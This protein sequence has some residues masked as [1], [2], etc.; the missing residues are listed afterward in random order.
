[1]KGIGDSQR[2]LAFDYGLSGVRFAGDVPRLPE[3]GQAPAVDT[4]HRLQLEALFET[5]TVDEAVQSAFEP[6]IADRG[7]LEPATYADALEEARATLLEMATA[8]T[9]ETRQVYAAALSVLE[10][11]A[12]DRVILDVA[13][14]VLMRG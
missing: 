12:Q 7:V 14:R 5:R 1:M 11:T 8:A 6:A 10:A 2:L 9:G 13:R 3:D 4:Q